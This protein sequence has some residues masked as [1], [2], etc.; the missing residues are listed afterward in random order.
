[1]A[2]KIALFMG[3]II[4]NFQSEVAMAVADT[5]EGLGYE[6]EVFSNFGSYGEN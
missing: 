1:M 5:A 4:Q 3:Q 2:K 6:L